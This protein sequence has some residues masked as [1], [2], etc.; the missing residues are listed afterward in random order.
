MQYALTESVTIVRR[1]D[2]MGDV[3][4]GKHSNTNGMSD[5]MMING[6]DGNNKGSR[7]GLPSHVS[8]YVSVLISIAVQ[9]LC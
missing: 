2:G 5:V 4:E 1:W 7:A 9:F 3:G 6:S 8:V